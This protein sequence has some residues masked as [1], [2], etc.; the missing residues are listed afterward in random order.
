M[1]AA[2]FNVLMQ[3]LRA[4]LQGRDLLGLTFENVSFSPQSEEINIDEELLLSVSQKVYQLKIYG[5][6]F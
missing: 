1:K 2:E 4:R 5:C 6:R 3:V